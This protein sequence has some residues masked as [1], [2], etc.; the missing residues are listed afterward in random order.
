M[1]TLAQDQGT[2]I[3]TLQQPNEP[4]WMSQLTDEQKAELQQ[5]L[6]SLRET[7]ATHEETM[8][9][10]SAKLEEW[11]IDIPEPNDQQR[12]EPPWMSE[13]T[14][15]QKAELQQYVESLRESGATPHE[16]RDAVNAKL[17]ALGIEITA[18]PQ[19]SE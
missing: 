15:D 18:P 11:D 10:I 13:L 9:A 1:S 14:D 12:P 2:N 5:M 19:A 4:P 8:I 17:E 7:G 16:I 3:E 6:D